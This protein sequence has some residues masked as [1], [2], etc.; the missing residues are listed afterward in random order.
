LKKGVELCFKNASSFIEDA[1]NLVEH[2]SYGHAR[3]LALSAIEEICKAFIYALN[4]IE[5]WKDEELTRDITNHKSKFSILVFFLLS[6][7]VSKVIKKGNM[8]INKPL[9][10]ADFKEM[11]KDLESAISDLKVGREESLYVD[12]QQGKWIS[13]FD[14]PRKEYEAWIEIAQTKKAEIELFCNNIMTIPI[15]LARKV[16]EIMDNQIFPSLRESMYNNAEDL[17]KNKAISRE[18]YEKLRNSKR[19]H[20]EGGDDEGEKK[21]DE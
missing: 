10:I 6:D 12:Y 15:E 14:I 8:K 17:Y 9:D 2:E 19:A 20:R 16:K 5:V 4:R 21:E 7:A 18:L 11:G 1:K 3:F 13:P